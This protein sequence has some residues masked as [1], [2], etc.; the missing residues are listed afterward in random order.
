MAPPNRL[1]SYSRRAQY[2]SFFG[3]LAGVL[4][5]LVGG[6]L[7]IISI[8]SP[9]AF[10]G[11]RSVASDATAPVAGIA[12]KGRAKSMGI[13]ETISGFVQSGSE[14]ARI[15]RELQAAKVRIVELQ[16]QS[17]ENKR[18]K[19]LLGLAEGD[20]RPVVVTRLISSTATS[21]RRFATLSAGQTE[22]VAVGMPVRSPMGLIGRVL[23][24]G[25]STSRVLLITDPE[26]VV[27][28]RRANDGIAAFAQ[29][30]TDGSI[31]IKLIGL[32]VNP[33]K[34][35]DAL[36]T[37]GSGGLYRPGTPIGV[38]SVLTRDGA[39]A[40]LLSD[41]AVTE[42]VAVEPVWAPEASKPIQQ[43]TAAQVGASR[44]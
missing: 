14:N 20:P 8:A 21:T 29:G 15:Q 5:A 36:V 24:V 13:A 23:E 26:S 33:L 2:T 32:G 9:G 16:A 44:P 12:S 3:Y 40:K 42:Y 34:V 27:P 41:P 19:A 30:R 1:P 22:G 18:L 37:S 7:L 11:L 35:G 31:Q 25:H 10:S 4:G 43:P 6:G 17:E 38:V 39:I 28:V